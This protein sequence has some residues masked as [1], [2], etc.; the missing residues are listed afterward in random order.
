MWDDDGLVN[1]ASTVTGTPQAK[2]SF[3]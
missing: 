2:T 3:G 1:N